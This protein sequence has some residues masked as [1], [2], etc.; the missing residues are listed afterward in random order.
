MP[1]IDTLS[2]QF[3]AN[4]TEKAV[5][6]IKAMGYAVR[7]LAQCVKSI[8]TAKLGAFTSSMETIKRSIP[9]EAQTNRMTAFSNAVKELSSVIGSANISSFSKDMSNLG[10]AVQTFKRSS[11]NSIQNAVT[12][13][14]NLGT[15]TQQTAST[16]S[17]V[18]PKKS[19]AISFTNSKGSVSASKEIVASLDR[20]E[21]KAKG[22]TGILQKMGI[23]TPT[24]PFK[25]L[26][27]NAEKIR[28]KYEQ[29]RSTIQKGLNEGSITSGDSTYKKKMAELDALRNKY[30]ELIQ[31]QK[32]LALEGKGF[33]ISPNLKNAYAGV[34]DTVSGV[35]KAF[36][37]ISSVIGTANKY[38][39]SFIGKL[40]SLGRS[41]K[42]V[43]K[44]TSSL[45]EA[46]K[47]L[48]NEFFRV[49]K[50]LKLMVTRMA[51]RAVIKEVGN[52]FKSLAIHS[53]EFNNSMSSLINGSK[54]LGYSF[55]AMVSPLI[56]ALAP[57]IVYII[58]LL[59]KLA[60]VFN[61]VISAITGASTWNKAKD[62][63]DS[64][65]DSITGAGKAAKDLKKTVLGFDELNQ[66][67]DNKDSSGGASDIKDMFETM[68]IESK[69]KELADKIKKIAED[70]FEPIKNAWQKVGDFVKKSWKYAL[71]EVLKL[72][73]DIARDFF[74][75]WKENATQ[76]I[77]ENIFETIGWIGVA[78]GNL[79]KRF[80]EAW[81]YNETGLKIL[82]T[83]RDIV[84]IITEHIKDMA[85]A[86]AEW[87]DNLDFKPL[88]TSI[89]GWL[90]SLKPAF[91]AV[92]GI[93]EDFYNDV[94][95]K[96][97]AWVIESGLPKLI[98]VFK[99]FNEEVK[100]DQL[101]ERLAELWKHLEPFM[102][103]VGEGLIIFIERVTKALA[104]FINGDDFANFLKK[105]EDWM[106]SVQPEDVA[107]G[108]EKLVKA[109][110][111]LKVIGTIL[112]LLG[113]LAKVLGT[114]TS[115]A[116][117]LAM[118]IKGIIVVATALIGLEV[119]KTIGSW[120][121]PETYKEYEGVVGSL[122]LIKDT[123]LA[124]WDG[125]NM[126]AEEAV[127]NFKTAWALI[128]L[129][130]IA[131]VL[132][133]KNK[134]E[135]VKTKF[136]EIKGHIEMKFGEMVTQVKA[137]IAEIKQTVEDI[138]KGI[139]KFFSADNWTFDGVGE[140]LAKTFESAKKA[141][142]K[143]WDGIADDLNGTHEVGGLKFKINLPK[144]KYATGGFPEDGLFFANH[145]ELVGEFSNG[146]T[147]V[148]NNQ[149]IIA[150]IET[151]VYAAVSKALSQ[152]NGGS[153]YI[154]NEIIVDGDVLA[155]SVTKAQER[156][157]RRFSPSTV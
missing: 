50:M 7:N 63:T 71:D 147:A 25:A 36:N 155:R 34:K 97:T 20:V 64:W 46:A 110:I 4:G 117:G 76:K 69:W 27:D 101:R 140:G 18:T 15:A 51:L 43:K 120:F 148:A 59:T 142:G 133:I 94:V 70:L 104:E 146:K 16:I 9:T 77:F 38:I 21:V 128:Q 84:L 99:R 32:E 67:Q 74:K 79:A 131:V 89:Q 81:N 17:N 112:P 87:A 65:R 138:V 23:Y 93:L 33:S 100:W 123:A 5:K 83:I 151:G 55:A 150:G 108:I 121:D 75:V 19:Q 122:K 119:G 135:E 57:A 62:F 153:Q 107:D 124:L 10:E 95:L 44:D 6:N 58:N 28:Q 141:I 3:N 156:Q 143:I 54:K 24:K 91:D 82:R 52:G 137:K 2:I 152:N 130:F 40:R 149:Q 61:Q 145:N 41:S 111:G 53:D 125:W 105:L 45:T 26:A 11:V 37:G 14:Q 118:A 86:T 31:K 116:G 13:M 68:P 113:G 78:V 22:V 1:N 29:L 115:V 136:T 144:V 134:I 90:E 129:I 42:S 49:S 154:A 8:D 12:A 72:G 92:M 85:K 80:R 96:F 39:N 139:K 102:E 132:E 103:T 73:Q 88:L 126:A 66:L 35:K 127:K 48:S 106:D 109:I 157:G 47:K 60:N 98:D 114:L 56:N 30:D